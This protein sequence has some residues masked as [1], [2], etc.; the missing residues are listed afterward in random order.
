[1]VLTYAIIISARMNIVADA[2]KQEFLRNAFAATENIVNI[3]IFV[4]KTLLLVLYNNH[5]HHHDHHH[6][7]HDHHHHP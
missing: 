5:H 3:A 2:R 7:H 1:M 4:K 6:D